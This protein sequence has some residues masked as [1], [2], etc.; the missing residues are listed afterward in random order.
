MKERFELS[1]TVEAETKLLF[2]Y[3][4][5]VWGSDKVWYCSVVSA[6]ETSQF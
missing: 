4:L 2:G 6:G 1:T 5:L 3:G